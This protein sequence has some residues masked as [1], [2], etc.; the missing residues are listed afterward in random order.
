MN[1]RDYLYE[2]RIDP[3]AFAYA[4]NIS[5]SSL[6]RYMGGHCP[7]LRIAIKIEQ[8]TDGHVTVE[9]L[10]KNKKVRNARRKHNTSTSV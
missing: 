1:L 5:I 3:V 10:M 7:H 6:Y 4:T 2:H 9:E 8:A